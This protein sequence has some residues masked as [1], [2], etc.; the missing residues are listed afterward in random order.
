MTVLALGSVRSCAVTTTAA[1]LAMIW[2]GEDRRV[3]IE[4][5]PAGGT[6]AV[7]CVLSAEPG[8]VSWAAAAR[9]DPDPTSVFDH[10]QALPDGTQVVCGP[11]GG[12]QARSALSMLGSTLGRLGELDG[13]VLADCGRLDRSGSN[14]RLFDVAALSILVCRPQ[15]GD[16]NAL[17]AFLETQATESGRQRVL[18]VGPGP[19][20]SGEIADTLGVD[21]VGHLPWDADAASWLATL[22]P[23]ARRLTRTS[24][25]RALR[26]L[27]DDMTALLWGGRPEESSDNN[28]G[29]NVSLVAEAAR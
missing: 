2:P 26:S 22:P 28:R 12:D 5:D 19:Y 23:S 4:A 9:R 3:L 16:L 8:L 27:A 17:A 18:L 25:V 20:P 10:T 15:L 21:V 7:G 14:A 13:L 29:E 24:L 11:P 6:L 1:G